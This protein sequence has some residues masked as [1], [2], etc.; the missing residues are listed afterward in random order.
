[1]V[2]QA[3]SYYLAIGRVR[4]AIDVYRHGKYFRCAT[5]QYRIHGRFLLTCM[6]R[7]TLCHALGQLINAALMPPVYIYIH[8]DLRYI[9]LYIHQ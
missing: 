2:L 8:A 7:P 4:E 3:V 1:V 5:L 6:S 9:L